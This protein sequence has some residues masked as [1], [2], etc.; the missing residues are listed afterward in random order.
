MKKPLNVILDYHSY[1][2]AE[3]E[4]TPRRTPVL[5]LHGT[6]PKGREVKVRVRLEPA[7]VPVI[8]DALRRL[9]EHERDAWAVGV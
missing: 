8:R 6:T 3:R 1:A 2:D 9:A 7:D 5:V 4:W